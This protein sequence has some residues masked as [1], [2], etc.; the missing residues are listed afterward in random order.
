VKNKYLTS[1]TS[2]GRYGFT[3]SNYSTSSRVGSVYKKNIHR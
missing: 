3:G 2:M 1:G